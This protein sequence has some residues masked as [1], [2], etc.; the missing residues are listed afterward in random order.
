MEEILFSPMTK[1]PLSPTGNSIDKNSY[2]QQEIQNSKVRTQ[3]RHQN[4]H[5]G[6]I[7]LSFL[8]L[9]ISVWFNSYKVYS[10]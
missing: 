6:N 2:H 1:K 10:I 3:E 4:G 9:Y 8:Q 5:T 7:K